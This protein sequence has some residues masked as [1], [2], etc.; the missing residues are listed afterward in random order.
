MWLSTIARAFAPPD[1]F[2]SPEAGFAASS[3]CHCSTVNLNET[4]PDSRSEWRHV[5]NDLPGASGWSR[6]PEAKP[7]RLE[8]LDT[9]C[10]FD[11]L[12]IVSGDA[13]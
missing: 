7:A 5:G 12:W 1:G 3:S 8:S 9:L 11:M 2:D 13:V 6:A 10:G 4:T